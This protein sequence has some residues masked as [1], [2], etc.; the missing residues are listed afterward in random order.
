MAKKQ[1]R[2]RLVFKAA[3]EAKGL[4][5]YE[6]ADLSGV[7]RHTIMRIEDGRGGSLSSITDLAFALGISS[8][9]L[10]AALFA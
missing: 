7:S 3:R 8:E 6:L 5:Q 9:D 1:N 4:T 10:A 2:L